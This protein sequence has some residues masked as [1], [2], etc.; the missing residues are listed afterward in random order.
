MPYC[1]VVGAICI[2]L[3]S[4]LRD[5]ISAQGQVSNGRGQIMHERKASALSALDHYL[6]VQVH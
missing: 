1:T 3:Y 4:A 2:P 5:L 6:I